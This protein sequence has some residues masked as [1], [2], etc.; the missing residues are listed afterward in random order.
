MYNLI[1]INQN[2]KIYNIKILFYG[3]NEIFM[4]NI[5][6]NKVVSLK[7]NSENGELENE[8]NNKKISLNKN[9]FGNTI[10]SI[11]ETFNNNKEIFNKI[12][13]STILT[14]SLS[15]NGNINTN[16]LNDL[17]INNQPIFIET[18]LSN[19]NNNFILM[20]EENTKYNS[21]LHKGV[22]K[23]YKDLLENIQGHLINNFY[24][25][26]ESE[27]R[28]LGITKQKIKDQMVLQVDFNNQAVNNFAIPF[29]QDIKSNT[30]LNYAKQVLKTVIDE[31][32]DKNNI[33][34]G[35]VSV[36]GI[37]KNKGVV[38]LSFPYSV[39]DN[40]YKNIDDPEYMQS[41]IAYANN[42]SNHELSH[43]YFKANE[44]LAI[45]QQKS[46]IISDK[47][48][49]DLGNIFTDGNQSLKDIKD[50]TRIIFEKQDFKNIEKQL[51]NQYSKKDYEDSF[52]R[53]SKFV[54]NNDILN[55]YLNNE[56][57][58]QNHYV[59]AADSRDILKDSKFV[60]N[61]EYFGAIIGSKKFII[62]DLSPKE[63]QSIDL[64][65]VMGKAV[66]FPGGNI[67]N[68]LLALKENG[69]K[70]IDIE[71]FKTL[72]S[73]HFVELLLNEDFNPNKK[74]HNIFFKKYSNQ[75]DELE[76][77]VEN[78]LNNEKSLER[79]F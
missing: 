78:T 2:D 27:L 35:N 26:N 43:L 40:V 53:L 25:Q 24:E 61:V 32:F 50:T 56:V 1:N 39:L 75:M 14:S 49:K 55:K 9:I 3:D 51:D 4:F 5:G 44:T 64:K 54:N 66:D 48:K 77:I 71:L 36:D 23:Q 41:F 10:N 62:E 60:N 29:F 47:F 70:D 31:R 18:N 22:T 63:L 6:K 21:N 38:S 20:N 37:I 58:S 30:D 45:E 19:K 65:K 28:Q 11:K 52:N 34:V 33:A 8:E 76:K 12:L 13:M 15:L 7:Y 46:T 67:Y 69:A 42:L 72:N 57:S 79:T 17:K 73:K 59:Y 74:D 68:L 16:N